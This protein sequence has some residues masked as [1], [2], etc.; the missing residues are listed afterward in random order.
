MLRDLDG[1]K[2]GHTTDI[3]LVKLPS[4]WM[5]AVSRV[6]EYPLMMTPKNTIYDVR[7]VRL[8]SLVEI[9]RQL[10]EY[11]ANKQRH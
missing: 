11:I 2:T 1:T 9:W 6:H 5:Y 10:K 3:V 7:G 8:Q 4:L